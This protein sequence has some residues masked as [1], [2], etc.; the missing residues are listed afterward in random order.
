MYRRWVHLHYFDV[1]YIHECVY[2]GIVVVV[3]STVQHGVQ[4]VH[5]QVYIHVCMYIHTYMYVYMTYI[6][7]CTCH[8]M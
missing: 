2:T 3:R 1:L 8:V 6:H 4:V 7:T 5:V